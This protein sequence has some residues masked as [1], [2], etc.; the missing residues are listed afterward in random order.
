[1]HT[2]KA[3]PNV[4]TSLLTLRPFS[5]FIVAASQERRA[6]RENPA[7]IPKLGA[8]FVHDD[9]SG[10]GG[11]AG[12]KGGAGGGDGAEGVPQQE[13]EVEEEATLGRWRADALTTTKKKTA[14]EQ[15]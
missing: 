9:R 14:G 2:R 1:M 6:I 8:F 13:E 4:C 11:G 12:S 5:F 10:G 7:V 3:R 15:W